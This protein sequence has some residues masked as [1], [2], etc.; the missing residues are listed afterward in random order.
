M[1]EADR[2]TLYVQPSWAESYGTG[3]VTTEVWSHFDEVWAQP[4]YVPVT[5]WTNG[6]PARV[7]DAA[8]DFHPIFSVGPGSA[9]YS[10]FWQLIYAD[11][12]PDTADGTLTSVRQIIDGHYP[13]HPSSSWVAPLSPQPLALDTTLLMSGG[14]KAGTGWVDGA[15]IAFT[16][17]TAA[18]ISWDQDLV[19]DEVPIFHFL[20]AKDDGTL[21]APDIPSVLG[22][23][24]LYAHTPPPIDMNGQPTAR[25]SAY[26]RV[27]AVIVPPSGRVFAPPSSPLAQ[28]LQDAGVPTDIPGGLAYDTRFEGYPLDDFLGRVAVNPDCFTS[29]DLS[30]PHGGTCRYLDSQTDIE[31]NVARGAIVRTDITVTCPVVSLRGKAVTP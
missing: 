30:D 2:T 4:M 13:L 5:G 3:Y 16:Q 8:G 28:A 12:P 27:Y 29:L 18:A 23:G 1:L 17:F 6:Q 14:T 7:V 22:T 19:V 31:S 24:P 26:W 20:F 10:P 15:P 11:V 9:F 21:V 25:Y